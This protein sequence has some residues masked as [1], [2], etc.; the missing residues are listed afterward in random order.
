MTEP[1]V[2]VRFAPSPTGYL[3]IGGARTA[4][5]NWL[6]ARKTGGVFVLR[7]E[8]TDAERSTEESYRAIIDAMEWLALDWDEGPVKGGPYGPYV[9]SAR[10]VLYH[11]EAQ[12]LVD[13]GKAYRCFCTTGELEEMRSEA[14]EKKESP[15]YDG[16][17]RRLPPDEIARRRARSVPSVVRFRMPEGETKFHDVIRG[18]IVFQNAELD[19]FVLIKSD[20]KPTYNFAATV[21]DAKMRISHVIRGDDHISNTPKQVLICKALDYPLPKF[22]HLPMILGSDRTRLSKRH[23]AASVQEFRRLGYLPDSLVNYLA[24]LG[25]AYDDKTEF[26]T[27]ESLVKKF[28][29]GKVTKNPAAFDPDK[30]DHIDGEHFKLL[31]AM[32]RVSLVCAK[33]E[34]AG[35][36]PPDF[37]PR[38]WSGKDG[39]AGDTADKTGSPAAVREEEKTPAIARY[40]DEVPRLAF[41]LKVMGSRIRNLKDAPEKLAYF[42]KNEYPVDAEAVAKHLSGPENRSRVRE[43]AKRLEALESFDPGAIERVTRE[44][45]A[46]LGLGAADVIHPCRVAITGHGV[47]PDIFS[48]V[49]LVGREKA[50][51]RL[52]KAARDAVA[53]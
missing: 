33:L 23:G 47:S 2:R 10:L 26:F 37:R 32:K 41:I 16:R 15:R 3:H 45:A 39:A 51:E 25:W 34:E 6:Y 14:A 24:L 20:G 21:D 42:Y 19:D 52:R 17:C 48:V 12:R 11:T 53:G 49:H 35:L 29:L 40:R 28:S 13:D 44:L 7:I 38:E 9:Q 30:L 22:A 8:D 31:D 36:L 46:E 1:Q 43:L 18:P 4:L 50:V 5:Y 27:R